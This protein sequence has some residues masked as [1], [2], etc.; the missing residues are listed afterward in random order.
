M[1]HH[2]SLHVR[3]D[4][5]GAVDSAAWVEAGH[6]AV[7]EAA[8]YLR[9]QV[10]SPSA[11]HSHSRGTPKGLGLGY[12][13]V[14]GVG[15]NLLTELLMYAIHTVFGRRH[16]A[17]H[18]PASVTIESAAGSVSVYRDDS[19][20]RQ[21]AEITGWVERHKARPGDVTFSL[22]DATRK[23]AEKVAVVVGIRHYLHLDDIPLAEADATRVAAV[24]EGSGW[25]VKL[26]LASAFS[27]EAFLGAVLDW[28]ESQ[29]YINASTGSFLMFYFTGHGFL[30]DQ[31]SGYLAFP[32][33]VDRNGPTAF[34]MDSLFRDFILRSPAQRMLVA[35]DCCYSGAVFKTLT[36]KGPAA[37][38]LLG[39]NNIGD[40][41]THNVQAT[42]PT[43]TS[44]K[45]VI[46]SCRAHE[47]AFE[48]EAR[49]A[50]GAGM[51]ISVFADVFC[52]GL[53]GDSDAL[54]ATSE[55]PLVHH[56]SFVGYLQNKLGGKA[57]APVD[58]RT[59]AV[60][61]V[62]IYKPDTPQ[63]L[64]PAPPSPPAPGVVENAHLGKLGYQLLRAPAGA[65][66]LPPFAPIPAGSFWMGT[67]QEEFERL[68]LPPACDNERNPRSSQR[69]HVQF[70]Y[71]FAIAVYPVTMAEYAL[72]LEAIP[73]EQRQAQLPA[74]WPDQE[75]NAAWPVVNLTWQQAHAYCSWLSQVSGQ[76]YE[77][78][79]EAEWEK[80]ARWGPVAQ[81]P[82][83]AWLFPFRDTP[84]SDPALWLK[85]WPCNTATA[86]LKPVGEY[87][88]D[89]SR[90]KVRDMIG[91]VQEWTRT[92]YATTRREEPPPYEFSPGHSSGVVLP[93]PPTAPAAVHAGVRMVLRGGSHQDAEWANI[94][95]ARRRGLAP[96]GQSEVVGF[97]LVRFGPLV[98][99][100]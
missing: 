30:D 92:S 53:S 56:N 67:A 52:A 34:S 98:S 81:A 31:K 99:S 8:G 1:N 76:Q 71:P 93:A 22:S 87:A 60:G 70:G 17:G 85:D 16:E 84:P 42:N 40:L 94:R 41:Q 47:L 89:I 82:Q 66:L 11:H 64:S 55:G 97:R 78:A 91:N 49:E 54:A 13:L 90:Y 96:T 69:L 25:K 12:D 63:T 26:L 4:S 59:P 20:Q 80:A 77:I 83:D 10:S 44:C 38:A 62:V 37:P 51:G 28:M 73:D 43:R 33:S 7:K 9:L 88:G 74:Q 3:F 79:S 36:P 65:Y 100:L 21:Q 15:A 18:T 57:Q 75:K 68:R 23:P 35:L 14:V 19:E 45:L 39:G 24:L 86:R 27:P 46:A 32:E 95:P 29:F 48:E 6:D 2:V 50:N 58:F 72:F 61:N 5:T